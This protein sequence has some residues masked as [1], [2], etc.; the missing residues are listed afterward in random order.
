VAQTMVATSVTF[1]D[2][3][4]AFYGKL[5]NDANKSSII[6]WIFDDIADHRCVANF[7]DFKNGVKQQ[8]AMERY[9]PITFG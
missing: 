5:T 9:R 7:V 1:V 6:R 4:S 2:A 3:F 8:I